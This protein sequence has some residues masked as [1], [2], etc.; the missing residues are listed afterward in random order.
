MEVSYCF[1]VVLDLYLLYV[2]YCLISYCLGS[3]LRVVVLI[4]RHHI[5]SCY[6]NESDP[7]SL[8]LAQT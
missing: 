7:C 3:K 4:A 8:V 2:C 1:I 5:A 6:S